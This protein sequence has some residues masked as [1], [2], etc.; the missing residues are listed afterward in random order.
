M[1]YVPVVVGSIRQ[2][3]QTPKVARYL[4]QRLQATGEIDAPY[5]DLA[6]FD[7]PPM[8]ERLGFLESPPPQVVEFSKEIKAADALVIVS[9]DYNNSYPGVLKNALDYFFTEFRHLPVG[10]AT[11]SANPHGGFVTATS[12][13]MLLLAMQAIVLPYAVRVV[14]IEH[15]FGDDAQPRDEVYQKEADFFI[16]ELLWYSRM[17]KAYKPEHPAARDPYHFTLE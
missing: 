3:R 12:L 11:V 1:L 17:V 4:Q 16:E 8:V 10:V 2:G 14:D 6:E 9:P 13:Q 15:S 5:L 7:F